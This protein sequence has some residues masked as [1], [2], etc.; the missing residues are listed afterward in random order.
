MFEMIWFYDLNLSLS[1]FILILILITLRILS[2]FE[3]SLIYD[4][5]ELIYFDT[6]G[7]ISLF[8]LFWYVLIEFDMSGLSLFWLFIYW[9]LIVSSIL[10]VLCLFL[11]FL[12]LFCLYWFCLYWLN[13]FWFFH[14]L[15]IDLQFLL[16][17]E[18]AVLV[19]KKIVFLFLILVSL[20]FFEFWS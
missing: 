9:V 13:V 17:I 8:L 16:L 3:L 5:S 7:L 15:R 18:F 19:L 6:S 12:C 1:S 20:F 2:E 10:F 11:V 14:W 4:D